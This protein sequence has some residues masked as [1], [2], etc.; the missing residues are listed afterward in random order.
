[1]FLAT[2]YPFYKILKSLALTVNQIFLVLT[3][4]CVSPEYLFWSR[5]FMI[6]STVLALSMFFLMFI[7]LIYE[8]SAGTNKGNW[9]MLLGMTLTGALAAMVKVTTF[10][11]FFAAGVAFLGWQWLYRDREIAKLKNKSL[12]P[13]LSFAIF[14]V[15][16]PLAALFRW[17][18]YC[19]S[20]KSLNPLARHLTPTALQDWPCRTSFHCRH[21]KFSL[22]GLFA[23]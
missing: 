2:F 15:L 10:Y 14:A 22:I 9:P 20:L 13:L 21:G 17:T 19:D 1:M 6:E 5:T 16:I 18:F 3:L 23:T 4:Y 8:K 7:I 12:T 11:A